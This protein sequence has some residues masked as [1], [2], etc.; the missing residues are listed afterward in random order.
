MCPRSWSE[1]THSPRKKLRGS[2]GLP[3]SEVPQES[4]EQHR[5]VPAATMCPF[6]HIRVPPRFLFSPQLTD[7]SAG[8]P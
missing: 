5:P 1:Q 4:G 8:L 6:G 7:D 3:L 2:E